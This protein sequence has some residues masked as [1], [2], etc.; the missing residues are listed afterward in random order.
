MSAITLTLYAREGCHL[1]ESM[2]QEL[3]PWR[4]RLGFDVEWVDV[5]RDPRLQRRHGERVP[6]LARG[7]EE[8]CFYFLDETALESSLASPDE[9]SGL[10]GAGVYER[11]YAL[12]E[13]IPPGQVATYGQL[14]ALEGHSTP[15]MAGYAMAAVPG[16][17]DI[18]WQR[19][20]NAGGRVS[21]RRGGGGTAR[22]RALLEAE[23][24]LFTRGGRVDFDLHGWPGPELEWL[25]RHGYF[26]APP[27]GSAHR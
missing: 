11:I 23:G 16:G 19:V 15:R 8:I 22:Q 9:A 14:A 13:R 26:P 18:P 21:E 1:C 24:V 2:W 6:V 27:P 10:R 17:R 3:A 25:E 7:D 5:D 4:G 20:I 12:V